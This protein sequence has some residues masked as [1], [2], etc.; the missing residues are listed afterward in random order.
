MAGSHP[1]AGRLWSRLMWSQPW[2]LPAWGSL[3]TPLSEAPLVTSSHSVLVSV[4]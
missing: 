1:L 4:L 3:H 2:G